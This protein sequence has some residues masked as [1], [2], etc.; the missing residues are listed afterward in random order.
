M[1]FFCNV[2][3]AFDRVW[4]NGLIF[5]LKQLGLEGEL[6]QWIIDYLY[7]RKQKVVIRKC[8]SRLR[9]VNADKQNTMT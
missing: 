3:K 9:R 6:I 5:K 7:D 1:F 8:S 4:L 2:S